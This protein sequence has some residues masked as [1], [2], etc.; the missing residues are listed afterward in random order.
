MHLQNYSG[1]DHKH[2]EPCN[3]KREKY[4]TYL[5]NGQ[6]SYI[7]LVMSMKVTCKNHTHT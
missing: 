2:S 5:L 4:C 3:Q 7:D 6:I 1:G